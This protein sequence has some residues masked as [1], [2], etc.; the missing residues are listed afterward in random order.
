VLRPAL[1][2]SAREEVF[3]PVLLF[4][5]VDEMIRRRKRLV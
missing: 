1:T 2:R 5:D 3:R 4:G